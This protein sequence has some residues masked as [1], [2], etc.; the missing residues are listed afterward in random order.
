LKE[1]RPDPEKT[2]IKPHLHPAAREKKTDR[3]HVHQ[4]WGVTGGLQD[5]PHLP[6]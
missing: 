4:L 1:L 2:R 6:P 3:G 5:V